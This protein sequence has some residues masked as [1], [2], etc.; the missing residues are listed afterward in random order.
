N[1]ED[2][3]TNALSI[4]KN[5]NRSDDYVRNEM[6]SLVGNLPLMEPNLSDNA[7][8]LLNEK[9]KTSLRDKYFSPEGSAEIT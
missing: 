4:S 1:F 2:L 9:F 3:K 7:L 5:W 8:A 6:K